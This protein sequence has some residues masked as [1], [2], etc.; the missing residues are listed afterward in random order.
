MQATNRLFS[1]NIY[2]NT[3]LTLTRVHTCTHTHKHIGTHARVRT[4]WPSAGDSLHWEN[5]RAVRLPRPERKHTQTRARARARARA[6]DITGRIRVKVS[7]CDRVVRLCCLLHHTRDISFTSSS[8]NSVRSV[9]RR[10]DPELHPFYMF[11]SADI[12]VQMNLRFFLNNSF[13]S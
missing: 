9:R 3:P 4:R 2:T 10:L 13:K 11:S 8:R 7:V 12:T 1:Q 6:H 5:Q